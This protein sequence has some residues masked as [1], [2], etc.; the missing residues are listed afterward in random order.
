MTQHREDVEYNKFEQNEIGDICTKLEATT[1]DPLLE[2]NQNIDDLESWKFSD[3]WEV[4]AVFT[5]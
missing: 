2:V 5:L 3:D 1:E 4:R